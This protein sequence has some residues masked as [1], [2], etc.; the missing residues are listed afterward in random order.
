MPGKTDTNAVMSLFN[1]HL[2]LR[3]QQG[4]FQ[5]V[6]LYELADKTPIPP[7]SGAT[8]FVP[9]HIPHSNIRALSEG[10]VLAVQCNTSAGFY[11]GTVAGYGDVKTYS[12]FL[13]AVHEV[14]TM[15]SS[16]MHDLGRKLGYKYDD[17]LKA[18]ISGVGT[19]V[20][21][22]G[23]TAAGSIASA[24]RLT[25]RYFFD[26][27]AT[28]G[29]LDAP[30]FADG[31]YASIIGPRGTNHLYISTSGGSQLRANIAGAGDIPSFLEATERGAQAI[32]RKTLG[33]LGECRI[34]KA[35]R[36][37]AFKAGTAALTAIYGVSAGASGHPVFT[38]GPGA[39]AAADLENMRPQTYMQGFGGN[40]AGG[41]ILEQVMGIGIKGYFVA[42]AMDAT[43]RL[44]KT[45]HGNAV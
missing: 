9:K 31:L 17:L 41:D 10:S 38:F 1:R 40:A 25:Q 34:I 7:H 36:S 2:R 39:F 42:I 6:A 12:D 29:N 8:V 43:N 37:T 33:V 21:P 15:I 44:V 14:P 35:S 19:F 27:G 4:L 45:A 23:D 22:D 24:T 30:K 28:L 20:K 11:S 18:V 32:E 13:V 3:A 26:A 16:D 5:G